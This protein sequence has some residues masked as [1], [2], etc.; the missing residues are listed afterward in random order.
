MQPIKYF[1]LGTTIFVHVNQH[2]SANSQIQ[3][4]HFQSEN[5]LHNLTRFKI[6]NENIQII[7]NLVNN[8]YLK[9]KCVP[10]PVLVHAIVFV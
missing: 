10:P 4:P 8:D 6:K 9:R 1:R 2:S 3:G 7:D 5:L